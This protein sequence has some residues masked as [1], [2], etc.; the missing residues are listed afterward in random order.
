MPIT[1]GLLAGVLNIVPY[2]GS[3]LGALLP[4]LVA[5]TISPV[6]ALLVLVLFLVLNQVE[7]NFL[8]PLVMG[9]AVHLHPAV[10]LISLLVLGTLLG[11][12]GLILAV[13]AAVVVATLVDEL[14]A[15]KR[16]ERTVPSA[17]DKRVNAR[18]S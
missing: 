15:E 13:P 14:T 7:G 17:D 2:L 3:T 11:V 10:V 1:F 18:Q 5:L 12:V 6:K 4:A 9:R 8:R 16:P